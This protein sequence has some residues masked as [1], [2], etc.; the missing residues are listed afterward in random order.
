MTQDTSN[1]KQGESSSRQQQFICRPD[2]YRYADGRRQGGTLS[3]SYRP[4]RGW[5]KWTAAGG[6]R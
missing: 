2:N 5:A 4:E 1:Q 6:R 3:A